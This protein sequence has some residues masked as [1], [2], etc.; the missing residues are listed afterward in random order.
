MSSACGQLD[1]TIPS[2]ER[3]GSYITTFRMPALPRLSG[4]SG[5]K[6]ACACGCG[7]LTGGT[8]FPGDDGRATGWATRIEKGFLTLQDVPEN[9]RQGALI[10]LDR[11]K[12]ATAAAKVG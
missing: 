2:G 10:M 1:Q 7:R 6:H 8:W 9:E 12:K 5:A 4:K 3:E 11:R